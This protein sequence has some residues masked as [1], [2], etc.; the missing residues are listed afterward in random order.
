MLRK[1][2]EIANGMSLKLARSNR[3]GRG[4]YT[5]IAA[6]EGDV[7]R[8]TSLAPARRLISV[9]ANRARFSKQ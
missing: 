1:N 6:I 5:F 3:E 8:A 7:G 4:Y 2:N 9:E